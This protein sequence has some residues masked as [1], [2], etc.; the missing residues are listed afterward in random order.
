VR[1]IS[2]LLVAHVAAEHL[3]IFFQDRRLSL[4]EQLAP[5]AARRTDGVPATRGTA[6]M[7]ADHPGHQARA[8]DLEEHLT[9]VRGSLI[10]SA[11][12]DINDSSATHEKWDWDEKP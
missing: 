3:A 7:S 11:E 10:P 8:K 6:R 4:Q 1:T 5:P 2:L 9:G 12:D